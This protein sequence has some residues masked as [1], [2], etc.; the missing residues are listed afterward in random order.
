MVLWGAGA[1]GVSLLN[2]LEPTNG[3]GRVVDVNPRKQGSYVP[4]SGT[5]VV[6]PES[7]PEYAPDVVADARYY[8]P[9]SLG[10]E[11]AEIEVVADRVLARI[12]DAAHS[13]RR[14]ELRKSV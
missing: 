12:V 4:G 7:L 9:T 2:A 11:A 10:A 14:S 1:K 5:P 3:I 6:A 13:R 8:Q